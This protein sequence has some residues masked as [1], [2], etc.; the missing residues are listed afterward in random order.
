MA[1]GRGEART[2]LELRRRALDRDELGR[3]EW[4]AELGDAP[5]ECQMGRDRG[6]DVAA[7]E[8]RR[9]RLEPHR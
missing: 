6:E 9:D 5:A 1:D 4:L 8:G 7:V 3:V 2:R